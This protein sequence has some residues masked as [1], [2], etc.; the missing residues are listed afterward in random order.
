MAA[1]ARVRNE[2]AC[3]VVEQGDY[4]VGLL[5]TT[6]S[7]FDYFLIYLLSLQIYRTFV[8]V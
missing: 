3:H 6:V 1:A 7:L 2:T 8:L 5:P 4:N